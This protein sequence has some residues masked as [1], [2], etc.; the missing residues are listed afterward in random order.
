MNSKVVDMNKHNA[1]LT[2]RSVVCSEGKSGNKVK[3]FTVVRSAE[4]NGCANCKRVC[5]ARHK[6]SL[7]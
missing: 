7:G 4:I 6:D 3:S 5:I 1:A 2:T